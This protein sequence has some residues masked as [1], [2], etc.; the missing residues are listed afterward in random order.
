LGHSVSSDA[1]VTLDSTFLNI[2]AE[3]EGLKL[4]QEHPII[5]DEELLNYKPNT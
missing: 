5:A 3:Q 4:E 1:A 2:T